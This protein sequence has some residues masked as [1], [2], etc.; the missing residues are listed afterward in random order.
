MAGATEG[1]TGQSELDLENLVAEVLSAET[2]ADLVLP[3]ANL[4]A[5]GDEE[6]RALAESLLAA[7]KS[8]STSRRVLH[9]QIDQLQAEIV[10]R[11]KVGAANPDSLLN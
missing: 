5:F 11:Y 3:G 2:K 10:N 9:D 4:G 6:L 1:W 7:E 8:V